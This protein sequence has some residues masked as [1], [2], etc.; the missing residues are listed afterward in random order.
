MNVRRFLGSLVT[1]P[2]ARVLR[3]DIQDI[4]DQ[5]LSTRSFAMPSE[6]WELRT[7]VEHLEAAQGAPNRALEERIAAL[8]KK[9]SMALGAVQASSATL[10]Q[11]RSVAEEALTSAKQAQQL[12]TTAR[13]TAESAAEGVGALEERLPATE[14]A[15]GAVD[16]LLVAEDERCRVPGCPE[17]HR[18]KGFC[19][20]HYQQW[21]R[22]A[23]P[24]FPVEAR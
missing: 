3:R 14:L 15:A 7:K 22:N 23:L 12:A 17:K 18:A 20:R 9:L 4:V 16:A 11:V 19:A 24:G 5:V 2:A 6:V 21:R 1:T 13:A 10:M 8:E